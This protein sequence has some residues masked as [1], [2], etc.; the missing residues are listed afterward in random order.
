MDRT[1]N[2]DQARPRSE[3]TTNRFVARHT[4]V[5]TSRRRSIC[6][7]LDARGKEYDLESESLGGRSLEE[8]VAGHHRA[9]S[10]ALKEGCWSIQCKQ[11]RPRRR[12]IDLIL[13]EREEVREHVFRLTGAEQNQSGTGK[14]PTRS[15]CFLIDLAARTATTISQSTASS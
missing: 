11:R 13:I 7:R 5:A 3:I 14:E 9:P 15:S 8:T 2:R 12:T 1:A 6:E 4:V 10:S